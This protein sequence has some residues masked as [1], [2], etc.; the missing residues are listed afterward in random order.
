LGG[1]GTDDLNAQV[2]GN[3]AELSETRAGEGVPDIDSKNTVSIAIESNG[4]AVLQEI[5]TRG[6]KVGKGRLAGHEEQCHQSPRG[7]ID[8]HE[9]GTGWGTILEPP[10]GRTVDLDQ[11]ANT[12]TS[13][14][15][16]MQTNL[17]DTPGPP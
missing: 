11:F 5:M 3:S 15:H 14:S 12:S 10:M 8:E 9:Q 1:I 13:L 2:S 16:G 4:L 6:F 17:L 7:V